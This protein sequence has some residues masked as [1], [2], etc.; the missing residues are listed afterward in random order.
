MGIGCICYFIVQKLRNSHYAPVISLKC[1]RFLWGFTE[2]ILCIL[3]LYIMLGSGAR[4][5]GGIS[6]DFLA[7][8]LMALLI[9]IVLSQKSPIYNLLDNKISNYLGRISFA[10]YLNHLVLQRSISRYCSGKHVWSILLGYLIV[11][12]IYSAITDWGIR[13]ITET[14]RQKVSLFNSRQ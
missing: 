11:V 8:P 3:V 13:K 2:F 9:I 7:L 1:E 14:L 5:V 6:L 4:T 12:I 10:I